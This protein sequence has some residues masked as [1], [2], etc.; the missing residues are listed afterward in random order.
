[1]GEMRAW[2]KGLEWL[3]IIH[4]SA[5]SSFAARTRKCIGIETLAQT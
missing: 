3:F 1:L 2:N 4:R 5:D